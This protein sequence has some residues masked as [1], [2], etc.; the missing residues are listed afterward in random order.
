MNNI[1]ATWAKDFVPKALELILKQFDAYDPQLDQDDYTLLGDVVALITDTPKAV[2]LLFGEGPTAKEKW[3]PKSML[4]V[5]TT[6]EF[7]CKNWL[8]NKERGR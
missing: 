3:F 1:T 6:G 5:D 2:L 8:L 7:Y 4:K